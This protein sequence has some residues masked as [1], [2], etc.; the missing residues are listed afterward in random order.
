MK[1]EK[2]AILGGTFDPV[3]IGHINLFHNI[4]EYTDITTL[5]VIPAYVSNFKRDRKTASFD[6]R[7]AMLNMGILDYSDLYP[8]DELNIVVSDYEGKKGGVS[9]TSETIK[10]L[11]D[12]LQDNGKVNFICGDDLLES[13]PQWHEY[14]YLKDHVRF[15]CFTRDLENSRNPI[16]GLEV[17][18]LPSPITVASSTSVREG[19]WDLL[20]PSVREYVEDAGLYR[21]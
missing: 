15:Y 19:N 4:S 5:Y 1:T 16:E 18:F 3:H 10:A 12:V 6:D 13:L 14:E 20:T 17:F 9:Y 2:K 21:D 7:M 11:F 8:F